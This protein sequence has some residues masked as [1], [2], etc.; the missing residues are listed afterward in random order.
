MD[1]GVYKLRVEMGQIGLKIFRTLRVVS[2]LAGARAGGHGD[3]P[4]QPPLPS[5]PRGEEVISTTIATN[6]G[7][8]EV[9]CK[10]YIKMIGYAQNIWKFER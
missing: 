1:D 7:Q 6:G 4:L 9:M 3:P 10:I 2:E 5:P 8:G